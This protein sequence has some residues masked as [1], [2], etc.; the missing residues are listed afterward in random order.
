MAGEQAALYGTVDL[1]S[2]TRDGVVSFDSRAVSSAVT[3]RRVMGL[4]E[5]WRTK[6][7]ALVWFASLNGEADIQSMTDQGTSVG[8]GQ[9]FGNNELVFYR[10]AAQGTL[11]VPVGYVPTGDRLKRL[12]PRDWDGAFWF[13]G[14]GNGAFDYAEIEIIIECVEDAKEC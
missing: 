9:V 5:N 8:H 2:Y 1:P 13:T 12:L 3:S 4:P 7:W 11:P 14:L 6:R 10:N